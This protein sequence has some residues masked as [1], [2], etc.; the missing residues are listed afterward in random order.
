M[1]KGVNMDK[2]I[3]MKTKL[4][5]I[6]EKQMQADLLSQPRPQFQFW[7]IEKFCEF[8]EPERENS[9]SPSFFVA[10]FL[11]S[12][13]PPERGG[14][15]AALLPRISSPPLR[16]RGEGTLSLRVGSSVL[17]GRRC[18]SLRSS[19]PPAVMEMKVE[20]IIIITVGIAM[21]AYV[22]VS[23]AVPFGKS[24]LEMKVEGPKVGMTSVQGVPVPSFSAGNIGTVIAE[25]FLRIL[26]I[27]GACIPG[28]LLLYASSKFRF[29]EVVVREE[30]EQTA[31]P[32]PTSTFPQTTAATPI[33]PNLRAPV[34]TGTPEESALRTLSSGITYL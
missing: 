14:G 12:F 11:S 8:C 20:R 17:R 18:C 6:A 32:A 13:F 21:L 22:F 4:N 33:M 3:E 1:I 25:A 34:L 28:F 16:G 9:A 15:F 7:L 27:L 23:M 30:P 5:S 26:G 29:E 10:V 19:S 31:A 2:K 24:L